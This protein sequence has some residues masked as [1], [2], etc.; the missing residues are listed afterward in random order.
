MPGPTEALRE[1]LQFLRAERDKVLLET[2]RTH[3][4]QAIAD[5]HARRFQA[6]ANTC[7]T[8]QCQCLELARLVNNNFTDSQKG[9]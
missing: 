4:A 8:K 1:V 5:R 2:E 7:E 3:L 9:S 6:G